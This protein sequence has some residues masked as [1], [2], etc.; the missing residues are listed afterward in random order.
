MHNPLILE[1]L[2]LVPF[3]ARMERKVLGV[4]VVKFVAVG[5]LCGSL[6]G[7]CNSSSERTAERNLQRNPAERWMLSEQLVDEPRDGAMPGWGM[8]CENSR[9]ERPSAARVSTLVTCR[10][11]HW[12]A[13]HARCAVALYLYTEALVLAWDQQP[14]VPGRRKRSTSFKE[15]TPGTI[16]RPKSPDSSCEQGILCWTLGELEAFSKSRRS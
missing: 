6:F 16:V 8:G 3:R 1:E 11:E 7:I 9:N 5:A 14:S 15:Q 12:P 10:A 13:H 2:L 4:T